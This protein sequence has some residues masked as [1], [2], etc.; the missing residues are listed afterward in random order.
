M[1]NL[2]AR[3][4]RAAAVPVEDLSVWPVAQRSPRTQRSG[5]YLPGTAAH[6]RAML[7]A[8]VPRHRHLDRAR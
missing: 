2:T 8:Q 5:R 7:P 4:A 3:T 1:R 6:P